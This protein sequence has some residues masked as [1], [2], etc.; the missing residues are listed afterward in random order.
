MFVCVCESVGLHNLLIRERFVCYSYC[1]TPR[2]LYAVYRSTIPK[3]MQSLRDEYLYKARDW[4]ITINFY[5]PLFPWIQLT[6][7]FL[8]FALALRNCTKIIIIMDMNPTR[9]DC[10]KLT[11]DRVGITHQTTRALICTVILKVK[12]TAHISCLSKKATSL[13]LV[14]LCWTRC[15]HMVANHQLSTRRVYITRYGL[16]KKINTHTYRHDHSKFLNYEIT[17][18]IIRI[19]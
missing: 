3:G 12:A 2:A 9:R 16:T 11:T 10:I 7:I 13:S 17:P 5:S 18:H 4:L 8:V 14:T 19:H 15:G 1:P 6:N